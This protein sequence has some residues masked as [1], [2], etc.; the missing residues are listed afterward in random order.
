MRYLSRDSLNNFPL[1]CEFTRSVTR[2]MDLDDDFTFSF[3]KDSSSNDASAIIRLQKAWVAERSAPD[4]LPYESR[5]L[6]TISTRLK[7]QVRPLEK[8]TNEIDC[9]DRGRIDV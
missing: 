9:M 2:T 3:L 6:E 8:S 7:Q 4:I 5:L 1:N